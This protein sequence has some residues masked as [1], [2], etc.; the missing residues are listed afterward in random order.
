[1]KKSKVANITAIITIFIVLGISI[2]S[3]YNYLKHVHAEGILHEQ[4]IKEEFEDKNVQSVTYKGDNTYIVKT[5]TK[6][7]VVI[8]EYYTL[9]NYKWKIYVL[10]KTRG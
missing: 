7:Y 10:E 1:M 9:M 2:F 6:E 5:D 3:P 4:G 8:Q